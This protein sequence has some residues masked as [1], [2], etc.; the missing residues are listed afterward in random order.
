[1]DGEKRPLLYKDYVFDITL[2]T[3]D[4][5]FFFHF[6]KWD[7]IREVYKSAG[8]KWQIFIEGGYLL[9]II[10]IQALAASAVFIVLP[11]FIKQGRMLFT[12]KKETIKY[13]G[14]FF[15]IG[16]GFMFVEISLI[17]KIILFLDHPVYAVSAVLFS[18][19]VFSGIG[20]FISKSYAETKSLFK[21]IAALAIVLVITTIA[22]SYI[23]NLFLGNSLILR[24]IITLAILC[25]IAILMGMPFPIGIR[26]LGEDEKDII[27]WAWCVN[28]AAS[29]ISS[30]FA[31]IIAMSFGFN[32]VLFLAAFTYLAAGALIKP[33][34]RKSLQ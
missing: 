12:Q 7:K 23:I 26:M 19:L 14:Y 22:L 34:D 15:F 8:E 32:A 31:I 27:P 18:I 28:G 10:F 3:D 33:F 6:F 29:V 21:I 17:Q 5:P 25:P 16:I 20:S 24:G 2:V 4:K 11:L 13:L 9:P 30:I 1:L